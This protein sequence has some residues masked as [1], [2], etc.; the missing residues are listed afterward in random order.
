MQNAT[1]EG[2]TATQKKPDH[3]LGTVEICKMAVAPDEEHFFMVNDGPD[4][5]TMTPQEPCRVDLL[6]VV[7]HYLFVH[8]WPTQAYSATGH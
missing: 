2:D 7:R 1:Y 4:R 8:A 6:F 5:D 3:H